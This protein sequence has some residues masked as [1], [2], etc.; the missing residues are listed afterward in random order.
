M[1]PRPRRPLV[2]TR[3]PVRLGV[4]CRPTTKADSSRP[5]ATW[6]IATTSTSFFTQVTTSTSTERG[7]TGPGR[8]SGGCTTPRPRWCSRDYRRRHA[9]YG[10]TP[11]CRPARA[12]L[13]INVGR[14]RGH[15]RHLQERCWRTISPARKVTSCRRRRAYCAYFEW[16][17]IRIHRPNS[18]PTRIYRHF[19]LGDLVDLRMLDLRQYRNEQWRER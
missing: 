13:F 2:R 15:E 7:A 16:I 18:D 11:T 6:R 5:T 10:R 12:R 9:Q 19:N 1:R 8:R 14:P 4:A 3:P 17:L